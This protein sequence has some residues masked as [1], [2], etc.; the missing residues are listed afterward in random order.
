VARRSTSTVL[1][2]YAFSPDGKTLVVSAYPLG[3][4]LQ[5]YDVATGKQLAAPIEPAP[6]FQAL[7][8]SPDERTVY[9]LGADG[10]LRSWQTATGKQ[11]TPIPLGSQKGLF[12][13]DGRVLAVEQNGTTSLYETATG[14]KLRQFTPMPS[15]QLRSW[16]YSP[17]G[18][19]LAFARQMD[20]YFVEAATGK[21]LGKIANPPEVFLQFHFTPDGEELLGHQWPEQS[22]GG[23]VHFWEVR[24]G[25]ERRVLHPPPH[26]GTVALSPDGRV[27]AVP[28]SDFKG[29]D[30]VEVAT[31][32]KRLTLPPPAV[33]P[34]AIGFSPD[35]RF[36]LVA[37][38]D[39]PVRFYDTRSGELLARRE[40]HRGT[41][42]GW[43]F[44]R[45]GRTL[46]TFAKD[47]T[48]LVWDMAELSRTGKEKPVTLAPQELQDLWEDLA[49]A[50][51]EKA[52]QAIG[53]LSHAP[54][55]IFAWVKSR[56]KPVTEADL[57]RV[58]KLI[59][60]LGSAQ[61]NVREAA[62]RA[63]GE[64]Q[65]VT[66]TALMEALAKRPELEVRRRLERLLKNPGGPIENPERLRGLRAVEL[67]ERVDSPEARRLLST[68]AAGA[69]EARLT[70]D[71]RAALD[72]LTRRPAAP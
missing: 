57:R 37:D 52:H 13:P 42:T 30:L 24:T 1:D 65:A 49:S 32:R 66:E 70:R 22:R 15:N 10:G 44:A 45:S 43:A 40:G 17:D 8:F 7:T 23:P 9:S 68:L 14:K 25:R 20:L 36:F 62:T 69:P 39:G 5:R 6:D 64:L 53:K 48:A 51:A 34:S 55:Q 33:W 31:V 71:A 12:A 26:W 19:T 63:L 38:Y 47:K 59:A 67:L 21:E 4:V 46:A 27:L 54:A 56:L 11:E 35:G 72:R 3:P 58:R 60:D 41:V 61:F 29:I 16:A 18:R 2:T 50:D 28:L